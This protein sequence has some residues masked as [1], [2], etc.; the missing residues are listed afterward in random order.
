MAKAARTNK[1][2]NAGTNRA[3]PT[4]KSVERHRRFKELEGLLAESYTGGEIVRIMA[5]RHGLSERQCYLDLAEVYERCQAEDAKDHAIRINQ[6]RRAWARRVRI[7]EEQGEQQAAN[8]ALERLHK[9]D[10]LFAPTKIE[11][12]L[13][14]GIT[15][16]QKA[17]LGALAL[18]PHERRARLAQIESED[19]HDD[20]EGD[21][22]G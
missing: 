3:T 5:E 17:L 6:A 19:G 1:Q 12:T 20:H 10:G 15:E 13:A 18:T 11:G 16:E 7:C 8:Y 2:K 22:L 21:E 14:I 9:L 4:V